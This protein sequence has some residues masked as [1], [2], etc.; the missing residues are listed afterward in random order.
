MSAPK[1]RRVRPGPGTLMGL[2]HVCPHCAAGQG[3]R[4]T[5]PS[6]KVLLYVH[7]RRLDLARQAQPIT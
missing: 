7:N 3:V 1:L 6:G 4:C 2:R 5:T